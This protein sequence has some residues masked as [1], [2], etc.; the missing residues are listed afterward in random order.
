MMS[1]EETLLRECRG[2]DSNPHGAFAPEDFK[3]FDYREKL[4]VLLAFVPSNVKVCKF[5]CKY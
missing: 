3:S 4:F 2:R 5:L 1:I